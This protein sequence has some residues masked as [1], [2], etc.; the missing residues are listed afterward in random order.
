[1]I[2][3]KDI[4]RF[5]AAERELRLQNGHRSMGNQTIISNKLKE[6]DAR[7]QRKSRSWVKEYAM[8]FGF[9]L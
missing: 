8:P 4:K 1:M 7:R 5:K 2:T 9:S 3:N 6:S